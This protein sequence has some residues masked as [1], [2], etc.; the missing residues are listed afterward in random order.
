MFLWLWICLGVLVG[1]FILSVLISALLFRG[2]LIRP[3]FS[4]KNAPMAKPDKKIFF[5]QNKKALDWL[6]KQKTEE[7][8]ITSDGLKLRGIFLNQHSNKSVILIHGYCA[9]LEYRV[10]D[11]PFYFKQGFNV[12]LIDLRTHGKSEGKYITLGKFEASDLL[13]WIEFL[14]QKTNYSKIVLDGVSMG[15]ATVICA[16]ALDLPKNVSFAVADCSYTTMMELLR[17]TSKKY[18]LIPNWILLGVGEGFARRFGKFSLY[19]DGPIH[20]VKKS[21]IPI[22]F[23]R[24]DDDKFIPP[25]MTDELFNACKAD[26]KLIKVAGAGH[27]MS[28][29]IDRKKCESAILEFVKKYMD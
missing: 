6:S 11:A 20:S 15:G 5:E 22:L 24:G 12:L 16:S 23:V 17:S 21:K 3:K 26:K 29:S 13:K 1:F 28:F 7:V 19:K 2:L 27:A 9:K 25:R 14:N 18:M 8:F 10:Q 4:E